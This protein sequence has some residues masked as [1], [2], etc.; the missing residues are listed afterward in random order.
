MAADPVS[1]W[2][3]QEPSGFLLRVRLTPKSA[4]DAIGGLETT[5]DGRVHLKVR[6]RAVPEKGK[7]NRALIALLAKRCGIAKSRVRLVSGE[8]SRLK[9]VQIE[10]ADEALRSRLSDLVGS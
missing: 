10:D 6:V 5:D 9:T 2:L 4:N 3:V 8:T 7:A 1:G